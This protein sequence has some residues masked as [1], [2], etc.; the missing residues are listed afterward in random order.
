MNPAF[1][2]LFYFFSTHQTGRAGILPG[3]NESNS[4]CGGRAR[5]AVRRLL[6]AIDQAIAAARE[7]E[8][9]RAL[10]GKE[11]NRSTMLRVVP[12]PQKETDGE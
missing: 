8:R 11:A 4:N 6:A 7:V 12:E 1:L 10:L 9:A 2:L 5:L 3:M